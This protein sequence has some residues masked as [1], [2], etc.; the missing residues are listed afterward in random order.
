MKTVVARLR[1]Q[2]TGEVRPFQYEVKDEHVDGVY[3]IWTDG[4]YGCDCNRAA[5]FHRDDEEFDDECGDERYA[6]L[7]LTVDGV[8][9]L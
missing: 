2:S 5:F 9:W 3:F 7:S 1:E 4:N 6:L 8:D